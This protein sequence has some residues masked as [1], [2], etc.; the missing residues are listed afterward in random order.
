MCVPQ[1]IRSII[2]K[3]RSI[4]GRI[5]SILVNRETGAFTALGGKS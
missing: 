3:N 4:L 5:M 2:G 1:K